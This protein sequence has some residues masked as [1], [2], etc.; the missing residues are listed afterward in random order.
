MSSLHWLTQFL[1]VLAALA[2]VNV[3]VVTPDGHPTFHVGVEW[4]AVIAS[5]AL[6]AWRKN[7]L[8]GLAAGVVLVAAARQTGWA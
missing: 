3:M 4:L 6:M 8:F 1:E 2:A 5:I 7:L